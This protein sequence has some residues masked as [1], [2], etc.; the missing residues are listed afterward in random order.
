M[1]FNWIL[2]SLF[3]LIGSI[4]NDNHPETAEQLSAQGKYVEA[5]R[6]YEKAWIENSQ[7]STLIIKAGD[8]YM[9]ARMYETAISSYRL[10][11]GH[12]DES[13]FLNYKLGLALK[14]SGQYNKAISAFNASL[15]EETGKAYILQEMIKKEITGCNMALNISSILSSVKVS[16]L[17]DDINSSASE[18]APIP[19]SGNVL[20][21]GSYKDGSS[22]IYK[23]VYINDNWVQSDVADVF[24]AM[25]SGNYAGGSF[26]KDMSQFYFSVCDQPTTPIHKGAQ[27]KIW[28]TRKTKSGWSKPNAMRDYINWPG[29]STAHPNIV[30]DG[31]TEILY[32]SSD[33]EGGAGGMDLWYTTREINSPKSDFTFPR[34]VGPS[35]NTLNDD[36]TPY[37][38]RENGSLYFSSNGHQNIGGLDVYSSSGKKDQWSTPTNMGAPVNSSA[39]DYYYTRKLGTSSAYLTSNR[40][41]DDG[42]KTT[43][44]DDIFEISFDEEEG[45]D[46]LG[47]LIADL[48]E[49]PLETKLNTIESKSSDHF[50]IKGRITDGGNSSILKDVYVTLYKAVGETRRKKVETTKSL[51]GKYEFDLVSGE[52]YIVEA[53]KPGYEFGNF[54]FDTEEL[55]SGVSL[56]IPL[57]R[58]KGYAKLSKPKPSPP[59]LQNSESNPVETTVVPSKSKPTPVESSIVVNQP[60]PITVDKT[61]PVVVAPKRQN[62]KKAY[63]AGTEYR[64][65]LTAVRNYKPEL[66]LFAK[67]RKYGQLSTELHPN[68]Q[69]TRVFLRSFETM[70]QAKSLIDTIRAFGFDTA[71]VVKYEDGIRKTL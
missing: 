13:D 49:A 8:N 29:S 18:Y 11:H 42:I 43:A 50:N 2:S 16:K 37:Y 53:F 58:S 39:D 68:G 38:D 19:A 5:A 61:E 40:L 69:L 32:F 51:D 10:A 41:I 71:F 30:Y 26:N 55:E 48:E 22:K 12:T 15:Q 27:C 35:I 7:A 1:L 24:S 3:L 28:I 52:Y 70:D 62:S 36:V 6:A 17:S 45:S 57:T 25:K 20:Y 60:K 67:A 59:S 46:Q 34:N 63:S 44:D 47:D 56:D 21:Y 65:Q 66:P 54:E 23:T 9:K 64:I 31:D 4:P 14:Q 33:R